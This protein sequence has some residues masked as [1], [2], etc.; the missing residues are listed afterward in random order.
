MLG[1][2]SVSVTPL[3]DVGEVRIAIAP[4]KQP[5]QTISMP[6]P[7]VEA[8]ENLLMTKGRVIFCGDSNLVIRQMRGEIDCEAP[9]LQLLRHRA[10]EKLRSRPKHEFLHMKRDWN[11]SAD[12]LAR[13]ALPQEKGGAPWYETRNE[14]IS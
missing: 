8:D 9:G 13:E 1:T 6:P 2:L 12:R 11:E 4:R 14:R 5:R 10:M 3:K 7:T